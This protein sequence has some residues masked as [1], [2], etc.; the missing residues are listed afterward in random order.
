MFAPHQSQATVFDAA[1]ILA[2]NAGAIGAMGEIVLTDP[3]SEGLEGHARYGLNEDWNVGAIV[4]T[5]DKDKNFRLGGEGIYTLLPD[6]EKQLGLSFLAKALY[7]RR[8]ETGGIQLQVGAILH[9]RITGWTNLPANLHAGIFWEP[10]FRSGNS[11]SGTQIELGSNFDIAD[12]GRTYVAAEVGL[13]LARTDSYVL[14][15][16]GWRLGDLAFTP[17]GNDD[18]S[19]ARGSQRGRDTK[20]HDYTDDDFKK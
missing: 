17:R 20:D 16:I 9:K 12:Q 11:S 13:K 7:L 1:D 14:L 8:Y 5:G 10:E 4:G 2:P 19:K 15:G 18:A 3:T 6:W